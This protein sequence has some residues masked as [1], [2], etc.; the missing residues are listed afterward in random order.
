MCIYIFSNKIYTTFS[1]CFLFQGK[2]AEDN[3]G[4]CFPA[5]KT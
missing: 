5:V 1:L 4:H 3:V 2:D